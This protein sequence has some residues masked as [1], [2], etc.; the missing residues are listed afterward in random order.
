MAEHPLPTPSCPTKPQQTCRRLQDA[1]AELLFLPPDQLD[2]TDRFETI[3]PRADRR[4]VW[5]ALRSAGFALPG[6]QLS[7]LFRLAVSAV[8]IAPILVLYALL[9]N[10][11]VFC[12]LVELTLSAYRLTRPGP[13]IHP[14]AAKPCG[15]QP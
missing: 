8:V 7:G 4:R 11:L 2:A 1:L 6:L 14:V 12:S 5:Q 3:V 9:R 13:S 10:G 15:T